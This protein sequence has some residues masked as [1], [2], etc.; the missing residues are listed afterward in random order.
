LEVILLILVNSRSF[1]ESNKFLSKI[2]VMG[3]VIW[4]FR[5]LLKES[6]FNFFIHEMNADLSSESKN[7]DDIQFINVLDF[8]FDSKICLKIVHILSKSEYYINNTN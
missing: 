6:E 2:K 5:I 7:H 8:Q 4:Y 1:V 3:Y